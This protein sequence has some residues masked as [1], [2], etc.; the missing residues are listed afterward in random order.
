MSREMRMGKF[1]IADSLARN[2][3]DSV[4]QVLGEMKFVP[5]RVEYLWFK[6]SFLMEGISPKFREVKKGMEIP[7]YEII[8]NDLQE[9]EILVSVK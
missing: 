1:Y 5:T 6:S 8:I 2:Q 7:F 4:A 9:G 3:S